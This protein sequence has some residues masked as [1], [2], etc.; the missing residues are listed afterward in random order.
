[1]GL[2][3][4]FGVA[5]STMQDKPP[6]QPTPGDLKKKVAKPAEVPPDQL[7]IQTQGIVDTAKA[8]WQKRHGLDPTNP[9]HK[10]QIAGIDAELL[11]NQKA[12]SDL[13]HPQKN[14]G[15]LRHVGRIFKGDNFWNTL[16]Q[17]AATMGGDKEG[18]AKFEQRK[19]NQ[20]ENRAKAAMQEAAGT[21]AEVNPYVQKAKQL[22]EAGF[23]D[24]QIKKIQ[25]VDTGL[26]AKP[27]PEKE[28]PTKYQPQLTTTTDPADGTTHYWRVPLEAGGKPE[29]VDFQGQKVVPKVAG[30]G[31]KFN[32]ILGSYEKKWGK[33]RD[34]FTPEEFS[35]INQQIAYDSARSGVTN[36]I[37]FEKNDKN[38]IVPVEYQNTHGP[39]KPPVDPHGIPKTA[40]EAKKRAAA[41]APGAPSSRVK[42][43]AP[44][45]TASNAAANA[46]DKDVSAAV[47]LDQIA[48]EVEKK[49]DDAINQKRLAVALEKISAG[50]FTTQA[51]DYIIKAGWGNTIEQWMH[52][53]S[54]GALPK[55]VMRQL[56][57]SA[58]QNLTAALAA[59]KE[60]HGGATSGGDD[61]IT[62]QIPGHPKGKIHA[63]Q[64]DAFMK[65]YPNATVE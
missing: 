55:D 20:P 37:R 28:I 49:P 57:D 48:K 21:P 11:K 15:A 35:F 29:E 36:S 1:M 50:R 16:G 23:T 33:K 47:K 60:A 63:S 22:K 46:A 40:G 10:E 9:E 61:M 7:Q 64:K 5:A 52:N 34:D 4:A 45:M 51:L 58:H 18:A 43:G 39:G 25:E 17:A 56:I 19:A 38:Q 30:A 14:P 6:A 8:L 24:D 12:L 26:A 62:V 42:V 53:P 41:T 44:I 59:Q 31:S 32:E 13:Y 65:K 27:A 54:T 2:W 3:D